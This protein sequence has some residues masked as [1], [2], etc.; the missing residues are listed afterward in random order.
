[1]AN[2]NATQRRVADAIIAAHSAFDP[3]KCDA[4]VSQMYLVEGE[5]GSGKTFT[6]NHTLFVEILNPGQSGWFIC[7]ETDVCRQE[8]ADFRLMFS[9]QIANGEVAVLCSLEFAN[10]MEFFTRVSL[11]A[12]KRKKLIVVATVQWLRNFVEKFCRDDNSQF[13]EICN[14][15]F[16]W[17]DEADRIRVM[18]DNSDADAG[19]K[20]YGFKASW[21]KAFHVFSQSIFPLAT[22]ATPTNSM[23]LGVFSDS[24][25]GI[26]VKTDVLGRIDVELDRKLG[27]VFYLFHANNEDASAIG[28]KSLMWRRSKIKKLYNQCGQDFLD[29]INEVVP[30]VNSCGKMPLVKSMTVVTNRRNWSWC[31]ENILEH[32]ERYGFKVDHLCP[33]S[34]EGKFPDIDVH[35]NFRKFVNPYGGLDSIIT[36]TTYIRGVNIAPCKIVILSKTH[37]LREDATQPIIQAG[38]RGARQALRYT[39]KEYQNLLGRKLTRD[40]IRLWLYYNSNEIHAAESEP[41]RFALRHIASSDTYY[42]SCELSHSR[43]YGKLFGEYMEKQIETHI[44]K[45]VDEFDILADKWFEGESVET[46]WIKRDY[47]KFQASIREQLL[48]DNMARNKN[49]LKCEVSLKPSNKAILEAAHIV[50]HKDIKNDKLNVDESDPNAYILMTSNAHGLYDRFFF[51]INE[52]GVIQYGKISNEDK[53]ILTNENI[54]EGNQ[55]QEWKRLNKQV[56]KLQLEMFTVYWNN[57]DVKPIRIC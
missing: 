38:G 18:P 21:A 27:A 34:K 23:D 39:I 26:T 29:A 7:S 56:I 13:R 14:P 16:V 45:L 48:T 8:V 41:N 37:D 35:E 6:C 11:N 1:M 53:E 57:I 32:C 5:T 31:E 36:K 28:L 47:R 42:S 24:S 10:P 51:T 3:N 50:P 2:L 25:L 12:S 44:E 52:R 55:I 49:T 9:E 19:Y 17:I 46:I 15:S 40:E 30:K 22:T 43:L 4:S 33:D 20:R 54:I